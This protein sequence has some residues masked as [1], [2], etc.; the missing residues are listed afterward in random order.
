MP[1][2]S[3]ASAIREWIVGAVGAIHSTKPGSTMDPASARGSRSGA[4]YSATSHRPT[5]RRLDSGKPAARFGEEG[6]SGIAFDLRAW[7]WIEVTMSDATRPNDEFTP[8][9]QA[10]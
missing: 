1:P 9:E 3:S 4:V 10:R 2:L 6:P 8:E 7:P 5:Q